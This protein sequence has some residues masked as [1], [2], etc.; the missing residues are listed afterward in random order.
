[1]GVKGCDTS[2]GFVAWAGRP[3]PDDAELLKILI[4]AGAVEYVRTTEPQA[5]VGAYSIEP[6]SHCNFFFLPTS[7]I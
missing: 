3:S 2:S 7:T 5:L 6:R 1:M 4:A